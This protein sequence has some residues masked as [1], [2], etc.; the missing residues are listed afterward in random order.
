MPDIANYAYLW[1]K[2]QNPFE[3]ITVHECEEIF[4]IV[5]TF[6]YPCYLSGGPAIDRIPHFQK[7]YLLNDEIGFIRARMFERG[8]KPDNITIIQIPRV[9]YDLFVLVYYIQTRKPRNYI[10]VTCDSAWLDFGNFKKYNQRIAHYLAENKNNILELNDFI[11]RKIYYI[12]RGKEPKESYDDTSGSRRVQRPGHGF[13]SEFSEFDEGDMSP[14]TFQAQKSTQQFLAKKAAGSKKKTKLTAVSESDS[15]SGSDYSSLES[16]SA[17][18]AP[19]TEP[20]SPFVALSPKGTVG[21]PAWL[22]WEEPSSPLAGVAGVAQWPKFESLDSPDSPYGDSAPSVMSTMTES[23]PD[24]II[25]FLQKLESMDNIASFQMILEHILHAEYMFIN[26][27]TSSFDCFR[28]NFTEPVKQ[29]FRVILIYELDRTS[30]G[31]TLLYRGAVLANDSLLTKKRLIQST[32]LNTSGLSGCVNDPTACTL[33]YLEGTATFE[34]VGKQTEA[35]KNDKIICRLKKFFKGDG[36]NED[37]MFFNPPFHPFLVSFLGG[38]LFHPRTKFNLDYLMS[39]EYPVPDREKKDKTCDRIVRGILCCY[40]FLI[41]CDYLHSSKS[42]SMV[43]LGALY[44]S[45]KRSGIIFKFEAGVPRVDVPVPMDAGTYRG[46][47][48]K[49][50]SKAGRRRTNKTNK[51]MKRAKR[52]TYKSRTN[53]Y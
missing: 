53:K 11:I 2:T 36:S 46:L 24:V 9:L 7:E 43:E 49:Y 1:Y 45:F 33:F 30:P 21:E 37:N 14:T 8:I 27:P 34:A 52:R 38:E 41:N 50:H 18:S 32:S 4:N 22:P 35:A 23:Q 29:I 31:V 17:S 19:E 13:A 10:V 20:P 15:E 48:K 26:A 44:Q 25:A 3:H 5:T 6:S 16:S 12:V 42:I 40:D 39:K 28:L 51:I 47:T